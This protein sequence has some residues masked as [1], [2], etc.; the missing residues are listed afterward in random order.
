[1]K[2]IIF[3][4][5][6][7]FILIFG[8]NV[9]ATLKLNE[10]YPAPLTGEDEWVELYNN[11]NEILDISNYQ[12]LDLAG[13]KIKI[14]TESASPFGF[15]SAI[16]SSVLNNSGDTVYLYKCPEKQLIDYKTYPNANPTISFG[17]FPDGNE[18]WGICSPTREVSN[19]SCAITITPT[20]NP[21]IVP[22][23][24]TC[25]TPTSTPQP[26]LMPTPILTLTLT[27]VPTVG[28]ENPTPTITPTPQSYDNIY[29]SETMINPVTGE[30][31]WLEIY[32]DNDFLVS[33]NN[34]YIDDLKNAGSSP[35]IFSLEISGKSY[36]VYNLTSSMF[37][38]DGDNVRLLDFNKNLKDDFEYSKTEQGKTLG[39][40][41]FDSD[42]FCLQEP[43]KN[44]VNNPCINLTPTI[45]ILSKTE[46][47]NL[48]PTTIKLTPN[49]PVPI[50]RLID[51]NK[52]AIPVK[53]KNVGTVLGTS[54]ELTINNPSNKP[55]INLLS[56]LSSF[57]SLLAIVSILI[58]NKVLKKYA[59]AN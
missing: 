6:L 44:S 30:K 54:D 32:N 47:I 51:T 3:I 42:D 53:T 29:I 12:L 39:R 15:V 36:G 21:I 31:E 1:M 18:N 58:K 26:T 55:L 22:P 48:S 23:S 17:R 38:N 40:T 46:Q 10:I 52:I 2:K 19:S 20:P 8:K 33:L 49:K 41:L 57:Y 43:S 16:S 9:F 7:L 25:P 27:I 50:N 56:F 34:W 14:S 37:N 5:I 59:L 35:K 24:F 4:A 28:S 45:V 13:N 11:E